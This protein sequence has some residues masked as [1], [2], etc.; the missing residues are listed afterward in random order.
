MAGEQIGEKLSD[1]FIAM[2]FNAFTFLL[3]VNIFL[4]FIGMIMDGLPAMLIF[5]P[6]LLPLA[7]ELGI[8][9]IHFGVVV[10]LNLMIGLVTPPVGGL[11]YIVC[12]IGNV[13]FHHVSRAVI[14]FALTLIAVLFLITYVP[15]LV[16]W[17]PEQVNGRIGGETWA[18]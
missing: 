11:L 9:P 5:V 7:L 10:V 6:V 12:K 14:P 15:Q 2:D 8:D 1:W 13:K 18:D 3:F 4:L 17:I 16:L